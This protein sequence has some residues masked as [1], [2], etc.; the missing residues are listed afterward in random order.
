M[1][2]TPSGLNFFLAMEEVLGGSFALGRLLRLFTQLGMDL[3]AH[4]GSAT[5]TSLET[6][7]K[8]TSSGSSSSSAA[9]AS[10]ATSASWGSAS[11]TLDSSG[12]TS[13][14]RVPATRD[15][16]NEEML[17]VK[18]RVFQLQ[19]RVGSLPRGPT[20]AAIAGHAF[21]VVQYAQQSLSTVLKKVLTLFLMCAH[22]FRK[23]SYHA[24][25]KDTLYKHSPVPHFHRFLIHSVC[26][27]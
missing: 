15:E 5:K 18:V 24:T 22:I 14:C 1:L 16:K 19:L 3:R 10:L 21:S 4:P 26:N 23:V 17:I 7:S 2:K 11:D 9:S 27:I 13:A 6:K 12:G 25:L 8:R 20:A